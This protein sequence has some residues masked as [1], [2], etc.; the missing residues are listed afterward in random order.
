MVVD[1]SD[2][3]VRIPEFG[4][5]SY[6]QHSGLGRST[7]SFTQIEM[8]FKPSHREGILLYN[9]YTLDRKG[10]FLALAMKEGHLEFSFDLGTG[11]GVIRYK[12]FLLA[13]LT[14]VI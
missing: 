5:Y 1:I 2:I 10:D 8:V 9:G 14:F 12:L 13:D 11:P 4:G 3:A 6:L 7:L